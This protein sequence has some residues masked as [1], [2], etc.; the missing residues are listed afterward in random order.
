MLYIFALSTLVG[1]YQ[2]YGGLLVFALYH[3]LPDHPPVSELQDFVQNLFMKPFVILGKIFDLNR[4]FD[5]KLIDL[6][7]QKTGDRDSEIP[8]RLHQC[9]RTV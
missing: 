4:S 2:I 1:S 3:S 5:M 6:V 9:E 7:F 8:S